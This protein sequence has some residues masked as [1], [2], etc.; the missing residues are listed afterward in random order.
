MSIV[1][2]GGQQFRPLPAQRAALDR[3]KVDVELLGAALALADGVVVVLNHAGHVLHQNV[4]L[5]C[6][7]K[8]CAGV[9]LVPLTLGGTVLTLK[10]PATRTFSVLERQTKIICTKFQMI[11]IQFLVNL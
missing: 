10:L 1:A 7:V 4:L 11:V 2:D 9:N 6:Q 5:P 8:S 3:L